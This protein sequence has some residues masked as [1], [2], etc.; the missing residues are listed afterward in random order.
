MGHGP[1][2]RSVIY[3]LQIWVMFLDLLL[4]KEEDRYSKSKGFLGF[5]LPR[6][7]VIKDLIET[8]IGSVRRRVG[9]SCGARGGQGIGRGMGRGGNGLGISL[10]QGPLQSLISCTILKFFSEILYAP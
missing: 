4:P 2:R 5:N 8:L 3:I 10:T 9:T 1:V 6:I 7:W